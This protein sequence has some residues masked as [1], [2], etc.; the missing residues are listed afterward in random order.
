MLLLTRFCDG[1]T[2]ISPLKLRSIEV[3]SLLE[4]V[5]CSELNI[6]ETLR[7][8]LDLIFDYAN[9][10]DGAASEEVLYVSLGCIEGHVS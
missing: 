2:E 7:L 1:H 4:S 9:I 10:G 5:Q 8:S 3:Q 6:A